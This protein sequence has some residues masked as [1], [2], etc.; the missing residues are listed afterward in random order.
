MAVAVSDGTIFSPRCFLFHHKVKT[1]DSTRVV[2][3]TKARPAISDEEG[4][5]GSEHG[6]D[7]HREQLVSARVKEDCFEGVPG[8][9]RA[10]PSNVLAILVDSEGDKVGEGLRNAADLA[11]GEELGA[12]ATGGRRDLG[13]KV[14]KPLRGGRGSGSVVPTEGQEEEPGGKE[15]SGPV[16]GPVKA[17]GG[18]MEEIVVGR[19]KGETE[20]A[21][22]EGRE[23]TR[24]ANGV[25]KTQEN[26]FKGY[27]RTIA[28]KGR[29][30]GAMETDEE[31]L[32]VGSES[33]DR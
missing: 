3:I 13:N 20:F 29:E 8:V 10:E 14:K 7:G 22:G 23:R 5:P 32:V 16:S 11:L 24:E 30:R 9:P 15:S 21:G 28:A 31:A 18:E 6:V 1:R 26:K 27:K 12:E 33:E 25:A 2:P 17:A 19:N 4:L